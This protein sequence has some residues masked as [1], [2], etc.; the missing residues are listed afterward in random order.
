MPK[1]N[2]GVIGGSGVYQIEGL[3]EV[4]EVR[5]NTPFGEPSDA[6]I[7]G[8]LGDQRIAFLPRHGRGHRLLPSELPNRANIYALKQLGVER[9]ISISAVGSM[10]EELAPLDIVIPDQL[11]DRTRNRTSTFF[12]AGLV[13]HISFAQP[14][15]PELNSVLY[16]AA[17]KSG[18][19]VHDGGALVVI[20]GPAFSTKAESQIYRKWDVDLIG[21]TALPEAKLAREAEICY[22]AIAMVT[23]YDVW[24]QAHEAVT[25]EMVVQNLLR[26]AEMGKKI[27]SMAVPEIPGERARCPCY[28]ALKDAIITDP[29]LIPAGTIDKLDLLVGKYLRR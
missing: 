23:D 3:R 9:I 18:A 20:E 8:S 21:M 6:F 28:K 10:R 22:S 17:Q 1:V 13:A 25:V 2:I 11:V 14:F 7:L 16:L 4:E 29:S 15:C 27:L 5:L 12:G 19:R 24:H 26:N